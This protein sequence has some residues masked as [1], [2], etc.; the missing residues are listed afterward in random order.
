MVTVNRPVY[1]ILDPLEVVFE[2]SPESRVPR[3]RMQTVL[4]VL[5][6]EANRVVSAE[7]L[8]EAVWGENPPLTARTQIQSCISGLRTLLS[9]SGRSSVIVTKDP[10]YMIRVAEGELDSQIFLSGVSAAHALMR[11]NCAAEAQEVPERT[12]ADV[13]LG[14]FLNQLPVRLDL[15]GATWRAARAV[16]PWTP[17]TISFRTAASRTPRCAGCSGTTRSR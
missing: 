17:R 2:G 9:K 10:G 5:L 11:K 6:L 12:G 3:G 4:T 8:M 7:N 1:R 16:S 13:T 14:L 15:T